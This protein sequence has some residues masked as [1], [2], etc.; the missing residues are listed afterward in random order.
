MFRP[1]YAICAI[2]ILGQI[3]SFER[4]RRGRLER[5]PL[6]RVRSA[7]RRERGQMP[8]ETSEELQKHRMSR[9]DSGDFGCIFTSAAPG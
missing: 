1:Q 9:R 8:S 3:A 2:G 7:P 6:C 4:R 5:L